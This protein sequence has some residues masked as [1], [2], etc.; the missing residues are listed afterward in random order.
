M[1]LFRFHFTLGFEMKSKRNPH[2]VQLTASFSLSIFENK[3]EPWLQSLFMILIIIII[4]NT[5]NAY[6]S[7]NHTIST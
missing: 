2:P 1:Q 6:Y 3:E 4:I 7:P 5:L